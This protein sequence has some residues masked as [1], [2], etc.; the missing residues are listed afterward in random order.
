MQG[1]RVVQRDKRQRAGGRQVLSPFANLYYGSSGAGYPYN[2]TNSLGEFVG[3]G[4]D[5]GP[6][7]DQ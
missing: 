4:S 5:Y 6:L 2:S 7:T 3:N 1:Q